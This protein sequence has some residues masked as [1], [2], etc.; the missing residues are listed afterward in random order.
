MDPAFNQ[1]MDLDVP[2]SFNYDPT[3]VHTLGLEEM[4]AAAPNPGYSGPIQNH[5]MRHDAP[6][7]DM[8]MPDAPVYETYHPEFPGLITPESSTIEEEEEA[9][10]T[11]SDWRT[12]TSPRSKVSTPTT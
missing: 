5:G 1:N 11:P 3:L 9:D 8:F 7:F 6:A 2:D 10:E 12:P 4:L